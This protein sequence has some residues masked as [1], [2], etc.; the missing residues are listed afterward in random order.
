MEDNLQEFR[1]P[2]LYDA[3]NGWE[4]DDDF[5][6]QL[7]QQTGEPVLDVACGT[8]RLAR[9]IAE[10]GLSVTGVDVMEPMLDRARQLSAHLTIS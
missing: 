1:Y 8:G 9:A 7:A 4:A 5:Y 2:E 6:L 3:E 10:S